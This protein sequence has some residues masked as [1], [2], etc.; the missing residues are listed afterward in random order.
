VIKLGISETMELVL[1]HGMSAKNAHKL[2][3]MP[4]KPKLVKKQAMKHNFT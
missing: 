4:L 3:I 2:E 1:N